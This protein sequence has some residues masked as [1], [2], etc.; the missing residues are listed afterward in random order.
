M[1]V[2]GYSLEEVGAIMNATVPAIKARCIAAASGCVSWVSRMTAGRLAGAGAR[3]RLLA[4]VG[5]FNARD[6]DAVRAMLAMTFG[7]IWWRGA[8]AKGCM[9]L[10]ITSSDMPGRRLA[11]VRAF[12]CTA[13]L[14]M[15]VVPIRPAASDILSCST[16]DSHLAT[17]RDF[18]Y[19]RYAIDGADVIMSQ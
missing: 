17:I 10:P 18:L 16:G 6:F 11:V 19:A 7:S 14:L 1:D 15:R 13:G 5:R 9:A 8:S 4:Y 3:A 12:R 2:L